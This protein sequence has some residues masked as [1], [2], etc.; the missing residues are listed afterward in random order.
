M[1]KGK[2]W[3]QTL[4]HM[5]KPLADY[6]LSF[7]VV[8]QPG[9][10]PCTVSGETESLSSTRVLDDSSQDSSTG[11]HSAAHIPSQSCQVGLSSVLTQPSGNEHNINTS[12]PLLVDTVLS[13]IVAFCLKGDNASLKQVVTERFCN[14]DVV[15]AKKL[16]W[17]N[18]VVHLE[19]C[20]LQFHYRHDSDTR[21]QLMKIFY[22]HLTLWTL[23]ACF[24]LSAVKRP[25]CIEFLPFP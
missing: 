19:A 20:G 11:N 3:R 10:M 12:K 22:M 5:G 8:S 16:L 21:S 9:T 25:S 14:E 2:K 24:L 7:Q 13:F 4:S 23:P 18:C 6:N 17:E 15:V 1:E